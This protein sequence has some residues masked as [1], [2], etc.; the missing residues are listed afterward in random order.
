MFKP[1]KKQEQDPGSPVSLPSALTITALK[2]ID[3]I[4]YKNMFVNSLLILF[5]AAVLFALI[6]SQEQLN[7]WSLSLFCTAIF[8]VAVDDLI[9][10]VRWQLN[11]EKCLKQAPAPGFWIQ[12]LLLDGRKKADVGSVNYPDRPIWR[13]EI[14]QIKSPEGAVAEKTGGNQVDG[15]EAAGEPLADPGKFPARVYMHA[16][17]PL[18]VAVEAEG[19]LFVVKPPARISLILLDLCEHLFPR[20]RR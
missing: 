12:P 16:D 10:W 19:M 18:P 11:V 2:D 14:F 7:L 8:L 6:R 9:S 17:G 5:A 3:E 13:C 1:Q 20:K 15:Q 4:V